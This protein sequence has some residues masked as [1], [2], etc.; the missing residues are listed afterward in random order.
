MSNGHNSARWLLWPHSPRPVDLNSVNIYVQRCLPVLNVCVFLSRQRGCLLSA[1]S[2]HILTEACSARGSIKV[3]SLFNHSPTSHCGLV[4]RLLHTG[5][6]C[7]LCAIRKHTHTHPQCSFIS[8]S[9]VWL[10]LID[11]IQVMSWWRDRKAF[12]GFVTEM[13]EVLSKSSEI[14]TASSALIFAFLKFVSEAHPSN[15]SESFSHFSFM[16]Q[17]CSI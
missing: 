5:F 10:M 6:Y 17:L 15:Q 7:A 12:L 2:D 16:S 14:W 9:V 13:C 4:R 11:H 8:A 1:V 3:S